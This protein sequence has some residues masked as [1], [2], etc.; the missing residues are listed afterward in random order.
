MITGTTTSGFYFELDEE[1]MDDYELL[2]MLCEIDAGDV[3]RVTAMVRMLLGEEQDAALRNHIR[4]KSGRV[5]ATKMIAEV[6]EIFNACNQ[7]KNS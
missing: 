1:V 7:G 2:D 6:M 3:S 5:P 4:T